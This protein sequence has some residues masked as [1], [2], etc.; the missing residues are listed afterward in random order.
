MLDLAVVDHAASRV[1]AA[2]HGACALAHALAR[3]VGGG[4]GVPSCVVGEFGGLGGVVGGEV[5]GA[6]GVVR[7]DL[8]HSGRQADA[9]R[10]EAREEGRRWWRIIGRR[11]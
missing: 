10:G 11:R 8:G 6:G 9:G 7:C 5:G 3:A 2:E 4:H 1:A